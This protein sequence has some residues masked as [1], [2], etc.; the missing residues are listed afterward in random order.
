MPVA[1]MMGE[2]GTVV[3]RTEGAEGGGLYVKRAGLREEEDGAE[4]EEEEEE[5][6]GEIQA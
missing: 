2:R 3:V 4:E 5:V 6:T 1:E